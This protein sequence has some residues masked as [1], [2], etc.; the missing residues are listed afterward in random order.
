[1]LM[2]A[3]RSCLAANVKHIVISS[4][5]EDNELALVHRRILELKP[6]T[7]ITS[8]KADLGCNE[9]WLRGARQ[10]ITPWTYILH[11]DDRVL[12]K[13]SLLEKDLND[14]IGFLHWDCAKHGAV[15]ANAGKHSYFPGLADGIYP[16]RIMARIVTNAYYNSISPVAG[17][18]QTEHVVAT[19]TECANNFGKPFMLRENMM[20]GNDLM[21]WL[22]ATEKYKQFRFYTTPMASYGYWSGSTSCIDARENKLLPIYNRTRSYWLKNKY[23]TKR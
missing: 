13:F 11:D 21:L 16:V 7:A 10:V 18:F 6:D 3:F 9:T 17:L 5:G 23:G 1:M 12:P 20:V 15:P 22:R 19:L 2:E 8:I 14:D 4:S